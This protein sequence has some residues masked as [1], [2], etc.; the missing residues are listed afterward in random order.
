MEAKTG[1][2][3][4][5][6]AGRDKGKFMVI[7]SI[8]GDFAYIADGRERK[9]DKPKKKRLKHIRVT[10]TVVDADCMATDKGL[11]KLLRGYAE[12]SIS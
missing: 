3:V 12:Q 5:S 4:R 9:L 10:N 11:R 8:E 1:M 2:I 7:V 6:A